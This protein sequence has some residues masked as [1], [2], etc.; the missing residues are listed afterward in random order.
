MN[1][2]QAIE[3]TVTRL[4]FAIDRLDWLD[5]R[6]T[7]WDEVQIDYTSLF[8]GQPERLKADELVERWR[9]LLPGFDRT[10]HMTGPILVE[11][12]SATEA[13]V[14]THVRGYHYI[15][16]DP[17]G[18]WMVAGHYVIPMRKTDLGWKIAGIT[19]QTYWQEG[20]TDLPGIAATR[21]ANQ[22]RRQESTH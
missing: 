21:A 15:A 6:G 16:A 12:I 1:D 17:G 9:S 2:R 22:P 20:N 14:E 8:G 13:R 10:Q 5:V 11:P 19:L 4:L 7:L 18:S 3:D